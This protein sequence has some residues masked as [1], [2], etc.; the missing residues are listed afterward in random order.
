MK[1]LARPRHEAFHFLQDIRNAANIVEKESSDGAMKR[2]A[3]GATWAF[4]EITERF[5][6]P[7]AE[8]N[9]ILAAYGYAMLSIFML[10]LFQT[11]QALSISQHREISSLKNM[12]RRKRQSMRGELSGKARRANRKWVAH[13]EELSHQIRK[14]NDGMSAQRIAREINDR[15]KLADPP[16]DDRTVYAHVRDMIASGKLSPARKKR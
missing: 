1:D 3:E 14:E 11:G 4:K 6:D 10:D 12:L 13:A 2:S 8:T 15:W 5:I 9:P 7:H 16:P